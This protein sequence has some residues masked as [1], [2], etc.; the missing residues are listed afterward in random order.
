MWNVANSLHE[1]TVKE[2]IEHALKQ[3]G[4][5]EA[6]SKKDEAIVMSEYWRNELKQL[7]MQAHVSF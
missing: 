3:R 2:I 6:E 1:S 7:P 4:D 5:I